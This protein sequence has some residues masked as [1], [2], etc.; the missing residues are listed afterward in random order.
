EVGVAV[1][2]LDEARLLALA[3]AL[4][5][6][7]EDAQVEARRLGHAGKHRHI[8]P[9]VGRPLLRDDQDL[10]RAPG[11]ARQPPE[12]RHLRLAE[13]TRLV[14]GADLGAHVA[15]RLAARALA[16]EVL[17]GGDEVQVLR[18][19]HPGGE[20]LRRDH[21]LRTVHV[22]PPCRATRGARRT[23]AH[24]SLPLDRARR[25]GHRLGEHMLVL[26]PRAEA[27]VRIGHWQAAT[28][29]GHTGVALAPPLD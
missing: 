26:R 8:A 7:R 4:A 21:A 2:R 1:G 17:G 19:R 11:L 3:E 22:D 6:A 28:P 13:P 9:A 20:A 27:D 5:V 12:R 16:L 29:T 24:R 25:P 23:A 15:P 14:P 10:R 18:E